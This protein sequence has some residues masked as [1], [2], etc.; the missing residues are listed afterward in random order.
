M[1]PLRPKECYILSDCR[2]KQSII[3]TA[4]RRGGGRGGG[5]GGDCGSGGGGGVEGGVRGG[6]DNMMRRG[7]GGKE[8]VPLQHQVILRQEHL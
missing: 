2:E 5:G 4:T 3:R 1:G 6:R 8:T 7:E